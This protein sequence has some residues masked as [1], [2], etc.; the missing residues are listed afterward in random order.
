M[1]KKLINYKHDRIGIQNVYK[2]VWRIIYKSINKL[3]KETILEEKDTSSFL[4]SWSYVPNDSSW[5]TMTIQTAD[6]LFR[7]VNRAVVAHKGNEMVVI[8]RIVPKPSQV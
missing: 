2:M 4:E 6:N 5:I 3:A 8:E 7:T 1:M